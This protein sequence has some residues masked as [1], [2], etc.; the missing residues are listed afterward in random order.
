M[1]IGYE[2]KKSINY[3]I[4]TLVKF[5]SIEKHPNNINYVYIFFK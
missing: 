2:M 1:N 3:I 4:D 5:L